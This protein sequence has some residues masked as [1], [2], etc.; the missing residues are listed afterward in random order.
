MHKDL[1]GKCVRGGT[2]SGHLKWSISQLVFVEVMFMV[3]NT[4]DLLFQ[5]THLHKMFA[6][7]VNGIPTV[8]AVMSGTFTLSHGVQS[9]CRL[10]LEFGVMMVAAV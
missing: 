8:S 10:F 3:P 4:L 9:D 7:V 5:M 1:G 2:I 6:V